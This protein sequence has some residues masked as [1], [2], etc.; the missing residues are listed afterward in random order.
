MWRHSDPLVSLLLSH[1]AR[2][3]PPSSQQPQYL[4]LFLTVLSLSALL[5]FFIS[6]FLLFRDCH[7]LGV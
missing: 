3:T 7:G 6:L 2:F 1:G 4:F 5:L